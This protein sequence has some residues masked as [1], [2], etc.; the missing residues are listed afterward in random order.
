MLRN[1][2]L[3]Q[4]ISPR[5]GCGAH[6]RG[7]FYLIRNNRVSCSMKLLDT[8]NSYDIRTCTLDI[9]THAVQKIGNIDHMRLLS[10]ILYY[11]ASFSKRCCKHNVDCRANRLHIKVYM[12]SHKPVR[13]CR[14]HSVC[15]IYLSP[16]RL[17]AVDMLVYRSCS[18]ITA[19]RKRDMCILVFSK[20][21]TE[22]VI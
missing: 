2:I 19:S 1:N 21:S 8:L 5:G 22:E 14:N 12:A 9:C 7:S 18:D 16:H 20:K 13:R 3:D 4:N 11:R 6:E 10:G 17:K 15:C